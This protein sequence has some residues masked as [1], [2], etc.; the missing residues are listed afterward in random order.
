MQRAS[1]PEIYTKSD[2]MSVYTSAWV[3]TLQP[4]QTHD[5]WELNFP[6]PSIGTKSA[7]TTIVEVTLLHSI[8]NVLLVY[9]KRLLPMASKA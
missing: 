3:V 4:G 7:I 6:E 2:Y 8:G 9:G 1:I 5:Y